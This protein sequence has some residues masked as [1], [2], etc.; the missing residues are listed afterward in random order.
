M[1]ESK[2][3]V[4]QDKNRK[5][6]LLIQRNKELVEDVKQLRTELERIKNEHPNP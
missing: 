6:R 3:K 4:I 1:A 2:L 5:L